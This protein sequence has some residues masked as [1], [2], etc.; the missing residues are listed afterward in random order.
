[1]SRCKPKN[2]KGHIIRLTAA[3]S[4][5]DAGPETESTPVS[6]AVEALMALGYLRAEAVRAVKKCTRKDDTGAILQEAL[7][8]L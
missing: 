5:G 2:S 6:D 4:G 7:R 8:Y 1:M 3:L